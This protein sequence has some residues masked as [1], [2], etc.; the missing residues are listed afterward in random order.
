MTGSRR[1]SSQ[2]LRIGKHDQKIPFLNEEQIGSLP[3]HDSEQRLEPVEAFFKHIGAT[4]QHGGN[5]AYY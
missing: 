2:T 4:I 1:K 3:D 5:S